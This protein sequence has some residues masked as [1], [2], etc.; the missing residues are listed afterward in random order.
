[1][2]NLEILIN[3][4]L[5]LIL[6]LE[7]K[8]SKVSIINQNHDGDE[9]KWLQ[10]ENVNLIVPQLDVLGSK[11]KAKI[12]NFTFSTKR[13]GKSHFVDTFS[14][15]LDLD[16]EH[17]KLTELTFYTDHS[18]FK[19]ILPLIWTKKHIGKILITR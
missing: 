4:H 19:A 8:D 5:N 6:E 13:W 15:N 16:K 14:G 7:I 9:G 18:L 3:L 10:A 12:N 1:M 17:L 11:V 2:E